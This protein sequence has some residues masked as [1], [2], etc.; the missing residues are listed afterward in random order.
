MLH[1]E[2][3]DFH[4]SHLQF[5]RFTSHFSGFSFLVIETKE[6]NALSRPPFHAWLDQLPPLCIL[7]G[8]KGPRCRRRSRRR[9]CFPGGCR[10]RP[11]S[12]S[13]LRRGPALARLPAFQPL[14]SEVINGALDVTACLPPQTEGD[15]RALPRL[16]NGSGGTEAQRCLVTQPLPT[17]LFSSA[18]LLHAAIFLFFWGGGR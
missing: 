9:C 16:H 4:L 5:R 2:F 8:Q 17:E 15:L 13:G 6:P 3:Q 12:F 11:S 1:L 18:P 10:R 7:Q 14:L